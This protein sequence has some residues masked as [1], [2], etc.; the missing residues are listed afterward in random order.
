MVDE[1]LHPVHR[2]VD[3]RHPSGRPPRRA[4]ADPLD[5]LGEVGRS[6]LV[7]GTFE[8]SPQPRDE[9]PRGQVGPG[10]AND[11][12]R[13]Q[14]ADPPGVTQGG[15]VRTDGEHR[16]GKGVAFQLRIAGHKTDRVTPGARPKVAK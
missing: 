5:E 13:G 2:L 11:E 4:G 3:G 8:P 16:V 6:E 1:K 15:G 12:V 14:V 9:H 7:L 10:L